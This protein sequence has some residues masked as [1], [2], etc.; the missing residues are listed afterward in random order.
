MKRFLILSLTVLFAIGLHAQ[1]SQPA[2]TSLSANSRAIEFQIGPNFSLNTFDGSTFSYKMFLSEK[3]AIRFGVSLNLQ[4]NKNIAELSSNKT[5][6]YTASLNTYYLWYLA[7]KDLIH[8]YYGTG[9]VI[10]YNYSKS[11]HSDNSAPSE[12]YY[13]NIQESIPK[14]F[15]AG[16]G[17][18]CGVEV[19]VTK[20]ISLSAE[21]NATAL[22]SHGS[23]ENSQEQRWGNGQ[24]DIVNNTYTTDNFAFTS[25]AKLGL[26]IYF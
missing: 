18:V 22:Y 24:I 16:I 23:S 10:G 12:A 8:F 4:M 2:D 1:S 21:Y 5:T 9:P 3:Q 25:A 20:A 11:H 7:P 19:F 14:G 17:G 6:N 13:E 15:S 26:I